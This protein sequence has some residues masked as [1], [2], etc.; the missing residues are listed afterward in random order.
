[1]VFHRFKMHE[2]QHNLKLAVSVVSG[3]VEYAYCGPSR[4]A[5]ESGF[6]NHILALMMKVC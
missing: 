5:G 3:D 6:C 2:E 1:M 4:A